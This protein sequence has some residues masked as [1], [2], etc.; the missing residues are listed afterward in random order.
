MGR[1]R[2]GTETCS[3]TTSR[4]ATASIR[5]EADSDGD[6][7]GDGWEYWS[8]KDLNVR[9]VPYPAKKPYPNPL[10][11]DDV[12]YDFDGDGMTSGEEHAAWVATGRQFDPLR[13][14]SSRCSAA[15]TESRPAVPM[16]VPAPR[17]GRAASTGSPSLRRPTRAAR[18][19][20]GTD[21][22]PTTSV[23]WTPT[24]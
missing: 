21:A 17:P 2:I 7:A 4:C 22:S 15:A 19:R 20:T 16:R 23:M 14:A 6:A 10:F 12:K 13:P 11:K 8:A 1:A 18:S 3:P 5:A 24:G 9:A